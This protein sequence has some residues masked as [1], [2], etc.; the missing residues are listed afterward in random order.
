M[1]RLLPR[2]LREIL[3]SDEAFAETASGFVWAFS[4]Q[5]LAKGVGLVVGIIIAQAYGAEM[6]GIVTIVQSVV[7]ISATLATLGTNKSLLSLLPEQLA[8]HSLTSA[9]VVFGKTVALVSIVSLLF[10]SALHLLADAIASRVFQKP[11]L[12]YFLSIAAVFVAFV[13]LSD[14]NT[15][16]IRALR[17][18]KTFAVLQV[19]PQIA[20]LI[21]LVTM[22]Y[23]QTSGNAPVYAQLFSWGITA[24]FGAIVIGGHFKRK[25]RTEDRRGEKRLRDIIDISLPMLVTT[26]ANLMMNYT[27][28]IV[29]GI[30]RTESELGYYAMAVKLATLV[31]AVLVAVNVMLAPKF[32]ELFHR[33]EMSELLRLARKSAG[34]IFWLTAPI[35][36][37]LMVFGRSIL[38]LFYGAEFEAA[39]PAMACLIIGQLVNAV[40]GSTGVFMNM[41]GNQKTFRNIMLLA[42]AINF[43]MSVIL[44]PEFGMLGAASAATLSIITWN[45]VTL[46]FIHKLYGRTIAY[47]P[48]TYRPVRDDRSS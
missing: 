41:T 39:Y 34:L 36:V 30:F 20:M 43:A 7:I 5:I 44:I 37:L 2:Y 25:Q 15:Q 46:V 21:A 45:V 3:F 22:T 42:V 17:L 32:A 33:E 28:I 6:V 38:G 11:H 12:G 48:F 13:A 1:K 47:V 19:F 14:L 4:S 8:K 40:S 35:L 10:A 16:M 23:L 27:A 29:F 18:I 24:F 9:F 31:S 26:I